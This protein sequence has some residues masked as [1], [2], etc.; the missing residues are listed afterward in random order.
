MNFK[1]FNIGAQLLF[2]FFAS[3]IFYISATRERVYNLITD[4]CCR[5]AGA[6]P[7]SFYRFQYF[8]FYGQLLVVGHSFEGR[9]ER[10]EEVFVLVYFFKVDAGGGNGRSVEGFP[11]RS[12]HFM[13]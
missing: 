11:L 12:V 9:N 5:G 6:V 13:F 8:H 3:N 10:H 7:D 4:I 1:P 2:Y